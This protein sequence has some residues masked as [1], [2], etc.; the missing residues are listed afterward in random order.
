MWE[1]IALRVLYVCVVVIDSGL[2]FVC[3]LVRHQTARLRVWI[4]QRIRALDGGRQGGGPAVIAAAPRRGRRGRGPPP[5]DSVIEYARP[6]PLP[7]HRRSGT[8][9]PSPIL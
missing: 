6:S 9:D 4:R 5:S 1:E 3:S 2:A 7:A 8:I